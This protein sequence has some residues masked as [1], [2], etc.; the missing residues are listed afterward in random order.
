M[1]VTIEL[2]PKYIPL[3]WGS[4]MSFTYINTKERQKHNGTWQV[5]YIFINTVELKLYTTEQGSA[6]KVGC[7][8]AFI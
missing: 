3:C 8:C 2:G 5:C 1:G 6:G 7:C 4:I